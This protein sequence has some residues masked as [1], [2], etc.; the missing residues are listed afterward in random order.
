MLWATHLIDE[1]DENSKIIVLHQGKILADG[2]NIT[3]PN[4][5]LKEAFDRL[6]R[7]QAA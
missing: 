3:R 5:S 6:T 1:A 7:K 2:Q 4:E